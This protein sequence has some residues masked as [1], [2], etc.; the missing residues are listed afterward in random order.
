MDKHNITKP[1]GNNW[2]KRHDSKPIYCHTR[3]VRVCVCVSGLRWALQPS[4]LRELSREA[5]G[6]LQPL[7]DQAQETFKLSLKKIKGCMD[8]KNR[9]SFWVFSCFSAGRGINNWV[10]NFAVT[11]YPHCCYRR[12]A[13][14]KESF[15]SLR[16]STALR[17]VGKSI[18]LICNWKIHTAFTTIFVPPQWNE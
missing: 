12:K 6:R 3:L 18:H 1:E 9:Q 4:G 13:W 7:L 11:Q 10:C 5:R 2:V 15:P 14:T 16:N 8:T 17:G